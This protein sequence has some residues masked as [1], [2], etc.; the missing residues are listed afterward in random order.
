[1]EIIDR[2]VTKMKMI[3]PSNRE[4]RGMP[5]RA[6]LFCLGLSIP[7]HSLPQMSRCA[8]RGML[9]CPACGALLVA[10]W[11]AAPRVACGAAPCAG[12]CWL[13]QLHQAAL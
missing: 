9:C 8:G 11:S 2:R 1:M 13:R 6:T 5:R 12:R 3:S 7:G 10:A 4:V